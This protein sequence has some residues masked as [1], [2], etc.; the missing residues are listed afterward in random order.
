M[1]LISHVIPWQLRVAQ[2]ALPQVMLPYNQLS[3]IPLAPPLA[4][5]FY[6]GAATA[7]AAPYGIGL[8]QATLKDLIKKQM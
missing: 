7:T 4:Q 6:Y 3:Q 5:A 8:D 2:P 1:V